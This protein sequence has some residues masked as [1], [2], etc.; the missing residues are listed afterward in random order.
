MANYTIYA[1]SGAITTKLVVTEKSQSIENNQTELSWAL[2]MWNT[3]TLWYAYDTKNTFNVAIGGVTV[4]NTSSYGLV[5]LANGMSESAAVLMGSGSTTVTHDSDGSKVV[6]IYFRVAQEWQNPP[7]YLWTASGN[8]TLT[9][10]ARASQ[11]SCVTYPQTT[12]NVGDLGSSIYIHTNRVSTSFTHIIRY[13]WGSQKATIAENVTDNC[14][15]QLPLNFANEIPSSTSGRGTIYVDTYSGSTF[16][17]T[18]SV[19]FT[20]TVPS[21]IVPT[22]SGFKLSPINNNS[23]VNGWGIFLKDLSRMKLEWTAAGTYSSKIAYY[24]ISYNGVISNVSSGYTSPIFTKSGT[25]T[26][27]YKAVDTRGR[28]TPDYSQTFTVYDY[29]SPQ[30][31]IFNAARLPNSTQTVSVYSLYSISDANKNNTIKSLS[32]QYRKTNGSWATYSGALPSGNAVQILGFAE[33]SSYE[34]K[35]TL[36]DSV[37]NTATKTVYI[38]TAAVLLDF[39]AGGKGFSIGKISEKDAFEI[40]MNAHYYQRVRLDKGFGITSSVGKQGTNCWVCMAQ[41]VIQSTYFNFPLEFTVAR[42][43]IPEYSRLTLVFKNENSTDPDV[44]SFTY[45]GGTLDA[46]IKKTDVSTWKLYINKSEAY[47]SIFLADIK[48]NWD[49]NTITITYPTATIS[50]S[51]PTGGIDATPI[52]K[53]DGANL[54]LLNNLSLSSAVLSLYNGALSIAPTGMI[55]SKGAVYSGLTD[56]YAAVCGTSKEYGWLSLY[57]AKNSAWLNEVA[58]YKD[59][60]SFNQMLEA[61]KG[62]NVYNEVEL[63]AD[64]PHIDFHFGNSTSDYTARIIENAQGTLTAYNS[65]SSASDKRLKKDVSTIPNSYIKFVEKL[66]PHLY[67]FK[68]GSEYLNAGLIAQEVME[69]EKECGIEESVL[70]RGTGKEIKVNGQKIMDYYSIDYNALL[71]LLLK[72]TTN[73]IKGLEALLMKGINHDNN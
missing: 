49:N 56:T 3:G 66:I 22:I 31:S 45:S 13:V 5:S 29:A 68:N 38:G 35:L 16:I 71:I 65:I 17:G 55:K 32:L 1:T 61:T 46:V 42:R 19:N 57:D 25:V 8:F 63:F 51:K 48:N 4:W 58:L 50:D 39:R 73:K 52:I 33:D 67:R 34:I 30:I 36:T 64:N 9:T 59:K 24:V 7:L 62:I 72:Y 43:G 44:S 70:V 2:Y 14:V 12:D 54:T 11:P 40:G 69:L 21:N 6:P 60:T 47:D 41:I 28:T 20:A 26:I 53:Y 27:Y 18:K 15:W 37:G 23:V 10:I